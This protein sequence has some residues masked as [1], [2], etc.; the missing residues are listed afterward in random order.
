[1]T[2]VWTTVIAN[3]RRVGRVLATSY[4]I[5]CLASSIGRRVHW[6][7]AETDAIATLY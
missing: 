5:E 4:E 2:K 3:G 7:R 1:M 6:E